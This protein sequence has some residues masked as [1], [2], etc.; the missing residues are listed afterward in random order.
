MTN[1]GFDGAFQ[2]VGIII[3]DM[4]SMLSTSNANE[5]DD[6]DQMVSTNSIMQELQ[7]FVLDEITGALT[8]KSIGTVT[9]I[10]TKRR[11][12]LLLFVFIFFERAKIFVSSLS[13]SSVILNL[14]PFLTF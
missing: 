13:K 7:D 9:W 2:S 3:D 4:R 1:A 6:V 10:A 14:I 8:E 11:Y 12:R 5:R